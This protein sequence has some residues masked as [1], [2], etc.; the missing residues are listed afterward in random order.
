MR[1]KYY[2]LKGS[3]ACNHWLF[4]PSLDLGAPGVRNRATFGLSVAAI[5][6]LASMHGLHLFSGSDFVP[7]PFLCR[8]SVP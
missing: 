2:D 8:W 1:S 7:L 3:T 6:A 4:E 5:F